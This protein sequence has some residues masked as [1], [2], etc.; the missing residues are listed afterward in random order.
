MVKKG[1]FFSE[2][3]GVST[4]EN[5]AKRPKCFVHCHATEKWTNLL[6]AQLHND[7]RTSVI[8]QWV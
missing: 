1:I 8:A 7:F 3:I 4:L 2:A 5:Y 6:F